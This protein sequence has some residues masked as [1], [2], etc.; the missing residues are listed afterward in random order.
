MNIYRLTCRGESYF[1]AAEFEHEARV[2]R[3]VRRSKYAPRIIP[4]PVW[5]SSDRVLVQYVAKALPEQVAEVLSPSVD[6]SK[7]DL[8]Y[9]CLTDY[10]KWSGM[11]VWRMW[12][13]ANYNLCYVVAESPNRARALVPPSWSE[14][15]QVFAHVMGYDVAPDF[16]AQLL[17]PSHTTPSID[18]AQLTLF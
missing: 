4:G 9:M 8:F 14:D 16:G 12:N 5:E 7:R 6:T 2:M 13:T 17:E 3:H 10:V 15:S 18:G 1:V 11:R